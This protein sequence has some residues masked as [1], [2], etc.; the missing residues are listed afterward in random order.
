MNVLVF[1]S[2]YPNSIWPNHGIFIKERMVNFSRMHP[3]KVR[4]VAP[5]PYFPPIKCSQR[6]W[7]SQVSKKEFLDDLEIYHP[8]YFM[9][10]KIG[11]ALY[12]V[13]ML[14]S[15]LYVIKRIQRDSD[16]D[17]LDAHFVYPDGFAAVLLGKILKKPVVVSARGSDV[18]VY[19][20]L[21]I[22][23]QLLKYTF[24]GADKI[25]AVS[26]ALKSQIEALGVPSEKIS[27][28]PNGVD[29]KTF[30]PVPKDIAREKLTL[31]NKRIIL[32]VGNLKPVKGFDLLLNSLEVLIDKY[33]VKDVFLLIVGEGE[34][35]ETLEKL[36]SLL[37]LE[38]YVSL[39]GSIPHQDLPAWYSAADVF[40]LTS[41][42]EGW[43][44]VI[45]ESLAC[46]TPVVGVNVGGIPEIIIPGIGF[47]T[48][49]N[50]DD[51]ARHLFLALKKSWDCDE[52]VSQAKAYSWDRAS[53]ALGENF[54]SVLAQRS[55]SSASCSA[56]GS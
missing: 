48:D 22:I 13:T 12:G 53:E 24:S 14:V 16:F 26:R 10:P 38:G 29:T 30:S 33:H 47:V 11:M 2:L 35:R 32:S 51:V 39:V 56:G 3:G 52:I 8:R 15:V 19:M 55:I 50:A 5:I 4:V 44:N 28:V 17:L 25:I 34:W 43:P 46:G 1:T 6:W 20:R 45:L 21:P 9:I 27:V 41:Q 23:R 36:I 40:C 49:R 42:A 37:G 18:N 54:R 31:P 7:Y